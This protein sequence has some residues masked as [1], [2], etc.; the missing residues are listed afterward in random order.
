MIGPRHQQKLDSEVRPGLAYADDTHIR[1]PG[2]VKLNANEVP[3]LAFLP[4]QAGPFR[5]P[6]F[7]TQ[8]ESCKFA[9]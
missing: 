6:L 2:R 9:P 5:A 8:D 7:M 4:A 3:L 1:K